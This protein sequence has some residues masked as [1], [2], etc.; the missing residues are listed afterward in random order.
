[1]NTLDAT[2]FTAFIGIDWADAK[3]DICIQSADSD[4]REF[5]VIRGAKPLASFKSVI[6]K[7][8]KGN[9]RE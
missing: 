8:L 9:K 1:M 6:D 5:D 3:H 2:S 4:E 7:Q